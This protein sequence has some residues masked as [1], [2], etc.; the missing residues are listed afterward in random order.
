MPRYDDARAE[1]DFRLNPP[2]SAP[3]LGSS[4]G[5][6]DLGDG[7][8]TDM[9]TGMDMDIG[10]ILNSNNQGLGGLGGGMNGGLGGGMN[11]GMNGGLG[12]GMN[13]GLGGGM[14]GGLGGGFNGMNSQ[15]QQQS[16]R[17]PAEDVIFDST[18]EAGKKVWGFSKIFVESL[19]NNSKGDWHNLGERILVISLIVTLLG[20]IL[21]VLGIFV[22]ALRQP[23]DV[24]IGGLLSMAMGICFL[25]F[26]PKDKTNRVEE[27]KPPMQ[28]FDTFGGLDNYMNDEDEEEEEESEEDYDED[29]MEYVEEEDTDSLLDSILSMGNNEEVEK[30]PVNIDNVLDNLPEITPGTQ[31]RQYLYET[32]MKVLPNITPDFADMKIVSEGS[33][34]FMELEEF[35]RG[36]AYQ[37]GTKEESIPELLEVRKNI[38]IVQLRAT[39]PSGLKEQEIAEELADRY[40]R[41]EDGRVIRT[42]VYATVDSTIGKYMI[43][44]FTGNTAMVSLADIYKNISSY[45][46]NPKNRFPFVW[47]ISEM[48]KE[49]YCDLYDCESIMISGEARGGKSWKGQSILAQL[50]MYNS[51]KEIEFYVFDHKGNASDYLYPSTV[52]PHV[53][54]F[55][56]LADKINEGLNA[57]VE[58]VENKYGAILKGAN[59][60]INIKDY[61]REHPNEKLSFTY[62]II[63]EL[64]SLMGSYDKDQRA[65]FNRLTQ[66]I[67]S[68]LPYLGIRLLMFPHRIVNEVISKSVYSLISTRAIVN[69]TNADF[70]KESIG[71]SPREFPYKLYNPGDMGISSKEIER[72]KPVFCHAEVLTETN[73]GN[74]DIFRFIG[75]VWRKLEPDCECI[76]VSDL[77]G[78]HVPRY[79]KNGNL[80][81]TR[82]TGEVKKKVVDHTEGKESYSVSRGNGDGE[83]GMS[84]ID[85]MDD[86]EFDNTTDAEE[87]DFWD[88][89]G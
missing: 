60:T 5:W 74:R 2:E 76:V 73:T 7:G 89:I 71:V 13:G 86:L 30:E 55:C 8:G 61:N 20:F 62:I 45:I 70:V 84:S 37:V 29:N 46:L 9:Y 50:C 31:T 19:R 64:M 52:L 80:L 82:N 51:P 69:A 53:K 48:G 83:E 75:S 81:S 24:L 67:T 23:S 16:Q 25:M 79:D 47:G 42:G 21:C 35:L 1:R 44:L 63:D 39:R 10:S 68:K 14:N 77:M 26:N 33:D 72:G 78:G 85:E 22:S 34:E 27:Q 40:S 88:S 66:K 43:N 17:K 87:E 4:E 59:Q 11:G 6:G 49:Y 54:Y 32:Y 56:G 28:N 38:F 12:G 15:Q 41:D 58:M 36:A 3:G 18:V 65:E 57:V